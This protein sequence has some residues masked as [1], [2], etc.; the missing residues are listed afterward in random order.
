[1]VMMRI[2]DICNWIK[3]FQVPRDDTSVNKEIPY[4]HYGDLYKLYDF[5]LDL[6]EVLDDIIKIDH[7]PKIKQEQYLHDGD[8]VFTLT[9]E[10]V[11]DL[12]H[13]TLIINPS[14]LP[15]VS[16]ME[17]TIFH[18]KKG[19]PI[20]PAYLNY[21]FQGPLFQKSLRQFV[22]GMKVYRVHPKDVMNM[23]LNVPPIPVQKIIVSVLD[24][25]SNIV[26]TNS[27]IN[28]N[29]FSLAG[30]LYRRA[31]ETEI[32]NKCTLSE[33]CYFQEGYVNPSQ[34]NGSYFDGNIKWLRAVD[35][36]ESFVIETSRTIT[37]LGFESAGSSA[38]MFE[39]NSIVI[40]KSGTIG[41]LG[42]IADK[43]CGNRAVIEIKVKD[44]SMMP[45]VYLY[46]KTRQNE[47]ADMA[48]GSVQKNLYVSIMES[49]EVELPTDNVLKTL[50]SQLVPI[51]SEIKNNCFEIQSLSCIRDVLLPKLMSGE[52]DISVLKIPS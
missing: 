20:I 52:I 14:E 22:T 35:I 25:I 29:L 15:F 9:S 2:G 51:F 47:F 7:N 1:M 18:I 27:K 43:M 28:D 42:I 6:N 39:P 30:S 46:L 45:F 21:C 5:R 19:A 49:L 50:N 8:I 17:T 11:D 48:V 40:S 41:R 31:L 34:K 38:Y 13:C 4:L 37:N 16:G 26:V 3:G 36:N 44:L 23:E 33:L 12:G 10:T 32:M 24:S